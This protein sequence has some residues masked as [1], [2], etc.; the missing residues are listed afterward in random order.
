MNIII[1]GAGKKCEQL[2]QKIDEEYRDIYVTSIID[3]Y[4]C[5]E[6]FGHN[7]QR[8]SNEMLDT[9]NKEQIIVIATSR[10]NAFDI[11]SNLI[12]NGF[13]NIFFYIGK[14]KTF[15]NDFIK[16]ECIALRNMQIDKMLPSVEMH[17]TDYCNLNCVG[18]V[19]FSPIFEKKNPDFNRRIKDL[20]KL[21][22]LFGDSILIISLLGGE[23]LLNSQVTNY[24]KVAREVFPDS[25][26]ELVT[27]GLLLP[28]MKEVFFE[29]SH[30]NNITLVVSE[31]FP[32]H[33]IISKI[34]DRFNYYKIDYQI[35][36]FDEKQ[37]FNKPLS[38]KKNSK[39]EKLC[40]SNG[41]IAVC[42]GEI[43]RCPTLLYISRLNDEFGTK[44]PIEGIINLEDQYDE[45]ILIEKLKK[46]VP[47]CDYCIKN[48]I[49][50]KRCKKQAVLD[51]FAVSE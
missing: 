49:Q 50:W 40:I 25:E 31:Y 24:M 4:F 2:L 28:N 44:F 33:K 12:K 11:C 18:C 38:T 35:R 39:Y 8:L 47:L 29:T 45:R 32:T 16:G 51:D 42:E 22:E 20:Y 36:T 21:K 6:R 13:F 27:N 10:I 15:I 34:V 17:I 26:I 5:G 23:P 30:D 37:W 43:A 19:H 7:V 3:S 48:E 14:T 1:Y 9:I 41:C 46:K